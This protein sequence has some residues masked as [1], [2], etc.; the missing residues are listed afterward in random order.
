[1]VQPWTTH[2]HIENIAWSDHAE[3]TLNLQIPQLSRPWHWRLNP[4]ILRDKATVYTITKQLKTYFEINAT[5]DM[6]PTTVW[7]AQKAT[8]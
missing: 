2:T 1:S 6:D 4:W 5:E 3:I 8:I 7:A